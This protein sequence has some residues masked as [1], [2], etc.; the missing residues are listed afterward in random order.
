RDAYLRMMN[1]RRIGMGS[2]DV[3][4]GNSLSV[5]FERRKRRE[6]REARESKKLTGGEIVPFDPNF[7]GMASPIASP[8]PVH[9]DQLDKALDSMSH[10][11]STPRSSTPHGSVSNSS[12][13]PLPYPMISTTIAD[14]DALEGG[15]K[16]EEEEEEMIARVED[17]K[18]E[19]YAEFVARREW[20]KERRKVEESGTLTNI[21]DVF[22]TH[23][24]SHAKYSPAVRKTPSRSVSRT[25]QFSDS[26]DQLSEQSSPNVS[27]PL[28]RERE[29]E[30]EG[31]EEEEKRE[32][33]D[34]VKQD[35]VAQIG[36]SHDNNVPTISIDHANEIGLDISPI[37]RSQVPDGHSVKPTLDRLLDS[38]LSGQDATISPQIATE[39][40]NTVHSRSP[41]FDIS[42][43]VSSPDGYT[44]K[45]G[46]SQ[47]FVE[48]ESEKEM[49]EAL[50][51]ID[52]IFHSHIIQQREQR[53]KDTDRE[54]KDGFNLKD[55]D[56]DWLKK[57]KDFHGSSH[58]TQK[59]DVDGESLREE[60]TLESPS[61]DHSPS[62]QLSERDIL[63][64]KAAS[65]NSPSMYFVLSSPRS[66]EDAHRED[67]LLLDEDLIHHEGKASNHQPYAGDESAPLKPSATTGL[68]PGT[69]KEMED[70]VGQAVNKKED[71][72]FFHF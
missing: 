9:E 60:P 37:S 1:K 35:G 20:E 34:R 31:K 11:P 49:S 36:Q 4:G 59:Q 43:S 33:F 46:D 30:R 3:V 58:G 61:I 44:F 15:E 38:D 65:T 48:S 66:V 45:V 57:R 12:P 19:E 41:S 71:S 10:S 22:H 42:S 72:G 21:D 70:G 62:N 29:R 39:H 23:V 47:I 24:I 18:E 13:P 5:V 50:R 16:E 26:L 69:L 55:T 27:Q 68:S 28:L 32:P 52:S 7:T 67:K 54:D 14:R 53:E 40:S 51:G 17:G 6:R 2:I 8:V 56:D 64:L 63:K 25:S